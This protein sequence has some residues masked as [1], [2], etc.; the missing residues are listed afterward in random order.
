MGG[1]ME[2]IGESVKGR[3]SA[4]ELDPLED[5]L[6]K[7]ILRGFAEMGKAPSLRELVDTTG[8]PTE[9]VGRTVEKLERADIL[10]RK[11]GEIVSAYPFSTLKT[12]HRV[13]FTG[14]RWVYAL[15]ATDA[16]G[17][18]FM[19]NEP[20]TILSRCP[21]CEG[22]MEIAVKDGRIASRRPEGILEFA[23]ERERCGCTAETCCPYINFFCS[24]EHLKNWREYNS[25]FARGEIYSLEDALRHGEMI[26]KDL[27]G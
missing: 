2:R 6:R 14:G 26:F 12:R 1:L 3:A 21:W 10:T 13:V 8:L 7:F 11:N 18:P 24:G 16:L 15:C 17:I 5:E 20:I 23:S 4:A 27:L 19:L 9:F 25:E 22:E